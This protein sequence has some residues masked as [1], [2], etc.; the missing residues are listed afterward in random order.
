MGRDRGSDAN[1]IWT[2]IIADEAV[3]DAGSV[4]SALLSLDTVADPV[5]AD[6]FEPRPHSGAAPLPPRRST[7]SWPERAITDAAI[8]HVFSSGAPRAGFSL[9]PLR[10]LPLPLAEEGRAIS[11][12]RSA[13]TIADHL[14]GIDRCFPV[15]RGRNRVL[16]ARTDRGQ[17]MG[18]VPSRSLTDRRPLDSGLR[19]RV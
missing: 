7:S 10:R 9:L 5:F 14:P 1:G 15:K 16:V 12:Q 4:N 18:R 11:A 8:G 19:S 2:L 6:G 13:S 3:T 17:G